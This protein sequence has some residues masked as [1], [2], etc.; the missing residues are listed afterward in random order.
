MDTTNTS[1]NATDKGPMAYVSTSEEGRT[2]GAIIAIG[3]VFAALPALFVFLR[4]YCR[5]R[6]TKAGLAADDW[7][8]LAAFVLN[9][10]MGLMLIIGAS[11]HGLGQPTPQGWGPKDYFW[12]TDDA[13]VLTEK[14]F[15]A[16]ILTQSVAFG[17]AK[18]SILYF[19]RR[20]FSSRTFKIITSVL[21]VIIGIWSVGF[22]FAYLFR[23]GTN[24]WALWAPLM[25]LIEY[26]YDSKPLFYTLAISDVI[27][28]FIILSLP[29][30]WVWRLNMSRAKRFA[31]SGVFLL[32]ALKNADGIGHLT[33]LMVWSMIEMSI[34]V[35]AGC[36]P[37]IWPLL[38]QISLENMVY[39][40]RSALSL[41]SL[42][43]TARSAKDSASSHPYREQKDS[44]S[45]SNN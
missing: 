21:I 2:P 32:G 27:T 10:G 28:D 3:A 20:I 36:L 8:M 14:I 5:I 37:T 43:G 33:T 39:T 31:V 45:V 22:F 12:V 18:L 11:L 26:C 42:Q 23:C 19:Y 13:E 15:F 29:L 1:S 38:H 16:F 7:L 17:L 9:F 6:V 4:F 44:M 30:F 25:Y 24:F 35:I 40:L 34:A 41:E